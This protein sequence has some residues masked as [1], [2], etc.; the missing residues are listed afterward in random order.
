MVHRVV[1]LYGDYDYEHHIY[2][3]DVGNLCMLFSCY[4]SLCSLGW[5]WWLVLEWCERKILLAS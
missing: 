3:G 5:S 2:F 4:Y 1:L